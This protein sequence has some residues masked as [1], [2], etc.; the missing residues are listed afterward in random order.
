[1]ATPGQTPTDLLTVLAAIVAKVELVVGEGNVWISAEPIFLGVSY[2][3]DLYVEVVPG[4]GTD[5]KSRSGFGLVLD[6]VQIVVYKR[7]FTDLP[8]QHTQLLAD[9]SVGLLKTVKDITNKLTQNFL[10]GLL[11]VPL[12]P[13]RRDP[14]SIPLGSMGWASVT[15][16]FNMKYVEN[17]SSPQDYTS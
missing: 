2:P 11:L 1:M 14:S 4:T 3:G 7:L 12:Y 15:R 10:D 17:F 8:E 9:A 6:Q 13:V 5:D 16:L